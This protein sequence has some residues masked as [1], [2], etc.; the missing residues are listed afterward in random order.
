MIRVLLSVYQPLG[1]YFSFFLFGMFGLMLNLACL[2]LVWLP[3]TAGTERFFQRLIHRHFAL[4]MWWLSFTRLVLVRFE[5]FSGLPAGR[6]VVMVA[7]HP[8]LMDITYLLARVPEAFCV[9]K[10]AIRRNPVLGAA[11]CRAGYLGSDGG[12]ELLRAAADKIAAGRTF[13]VFPEGTRSRGGVL[14]PL[15]PGFVLI[16]RR[17]A[18]PI[19]LVRIVS[20]C[21]LLAK[22]EVW[23][24]LPPL[25]VHVTVTLGP[26]LPPPVDETTGEVLAGVE[27]WFRAGP[28]G[29]T[30]SPA[31]V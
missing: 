13:I 20:D 18:A 11:A 29:A 26:C 21:D 28:L 30:S 15:K 25:P 16:A 19:Q 5:G 4:W 9:F 8:G 1:Y 2:A 3:A 14:H 7:N 10:P 12:H 31:A 24:R 27:G 17:A 6:G 23:W 22:G